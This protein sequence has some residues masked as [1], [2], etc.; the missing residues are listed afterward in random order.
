MNWNEVYR[1]VAAGEPVEDV[2]DEKSATDRAEFR[3]HLAEIGGPDV[4]AQYDML[5][6]DIDLGISTARSVWHSI[7]GL[8]RDVLRSAA[9]ANGRIVRRSFLPSVYSLD[10]SPCFL[11]RVATVRKLC[12]HNLFAWDGGI[13]DPEQAAVVTERGRFV[14]KVAQDDSP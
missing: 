8:Q 13:P 4:L 10:G 7:S 6:R 1:R 5:M 2:L 12:A 11:C 9:E 14:L 3:T